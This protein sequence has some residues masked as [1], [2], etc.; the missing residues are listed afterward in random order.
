MAGL[1]AT[2]N[3]PDA[4]DALA[5]ALAARGPDAA[6]CR[7][8]GANGA[9]LE[10]LVRAVI[11]SIVRVVAPPTDEDGVNGPPVVAAIGVD[12]VASMSEL[13]AGYAAHGPAGLLHGPEA[14][15][16]VLADAQAQTLVLARHGAAAGL[17]YARHNGGWVAASEPGAL[18]AVGVRARPDPDVIARFVATGAVDD[19]AATFFDSIAQVRPDEVVVLSVDGPPTVHSD[20]AETPTRSVLSTLEE[21]LDTGRIAVLVR[22]GRLGAAVVGAALARPE[23]NTPLPVHTV[24]F[25][26]LDEPAS[27]TP[28]VLAPL[29]HGTVRHVGHALDVSTLD[30]E[31]FLSDIGEPVPDL[32]L[33]AVWAVA[34]DLGGGVDVLIDS[35]RG[36]ADS[37]ARINDRVSARYGVCV[38]CPIRE[39]AGGEVD[40]DLASLINTTLPPAVARYAARDSSRPA[41]AR[42]IVLRLRDEVAAALAVPRPW[43]DPASL[44]DGLRRLAAGEPSDADL[45]LRAYLVERWLTTLGVD[46]GAATARLEPSAP[47]PTPADPP[48][49]VEVGD[50]APGDSS[51]LRWPVRV[52]PIV[53]GATAFPA[54]LAFHAGAV[55]A[56][57]RAQRA[58]AEALR[59]PWF[60]VVAGKTVAV[61]QQRVTP[62]W[63]VRPRLLAR[64]LARLGG[65]Q[66]PILAESWTMQVAI[67]EVGRLRMVG[68]V[69]AA[70]LRQ[71]AWL[72]QLLP[73]GAPAFAPRPDAVPPADSAVV[74]L[75]ADA[76]AFAESFVAALRLGLP[77]EVFETLAGC[78]VVRADDSGSRVLGF[79]AGPFGDAV[80]RGEELVARACA[81][82]PAG[83]G[84]ERT[85][86]MLVFEAP[87]PRRRDPGR[88]PRQLDV[89]IDRSAART[90][91]S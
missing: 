75:P 59:G 15:A 39:A 58:Y 4:V 65:R 53:A 32:D 76:D 45:L 89:K 47:T 42:E 31:G 8:D 66:L 19:T 48:D 13:D 9:R 3:V 20:S 51:W 56:E 62:L 81:D 52:N 68:A 41:G 16:V 49:P 14:Y 29:P 88:D 40:D 23:H 5:H 86:L 79:A 22:P 54:T 43:A 11:P 30:F 2:L 7:V 18:L 17:Y 87:A 44:V 73:D 46:V 10:V 33:Y 37:V 50:V 83:Q 70:L 67:A 27:H 85:P 91:S 12:G 38:R 1:A 90:R 61:A 80:T 84:R 71:H 36:R 82:N 57:L 35:G 74:Q 60:A 6:A 25:P 28:A 55:L 34:R 24:T 78:A 72:Q 63:N 64:V 21:A 77:A 26:D 69:G